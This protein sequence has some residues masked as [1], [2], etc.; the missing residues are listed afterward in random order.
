MLQVKR[1]NPPLRA[2][3]VACQ[4]LGLVHM[5]A[6]FPCSAR[7]LK[8]TRADTA[9][10]DSVRLLAVESCGAFAQALSREDCGTSL[11]PVVQKF[12]QVSCCHDSP[13]CRRLLSLV[14]AMIPMTG[15][16]VKS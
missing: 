12:A 3:L 1:H 8:C 9:D 10:Q 14:R 15:C 5:L 2:E 16:Y 6:L 4:Q 13:A 11:L 7:E